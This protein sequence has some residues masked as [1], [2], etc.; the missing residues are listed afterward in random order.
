MYT[1]YPR[2]LLSIVFRMFFYNKCKDHGQ[3]FVHF[4]RDQWV[5]F[6]DGCNSVVDMANALILQSETW[7]MC[8]KELRWILICLILLLICNRKSGSDIIWIGKRDPK[9]LFINIFGQRQL[10]HWLNLLLTY[11]S[12]RS[13]WLY[14][15][16][17]RNLESCR[18]EKGQPKAKRGQNSSHS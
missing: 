10:N 14:N 6:G 18:V 12:E 7:K 1:I 17:L 8:L 2:N 15:F 11:T 3:V 9:F 13:Q 5:G 16:I 4:C